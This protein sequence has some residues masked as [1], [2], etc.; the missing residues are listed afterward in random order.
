[1]T[2]AGEE[3]SF[4]YKKIILRI[5]VFKKQKVILQLQKCSVPQ[6]QDLSGERIMAPCT[7]WI[8]PGE[9]VNAQN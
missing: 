8:C 6:N 9:L 3:S 1:M 4:L 2:T 5:I 7:G